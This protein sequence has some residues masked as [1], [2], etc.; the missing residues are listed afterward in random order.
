MYD[1]Y[2]L[3]WEVYRRWYSVPDR[4]ILA[5]KVFLMMVEDN[6]FERRVMESHGGSVNWCTNQHLLQSFQPANGSVDHVIIHTDGSCCQGRLSHGRVRTQ[7]L[8][9][10]YLEHSKLISGPLW[11]AACTCVQGTWCTRQLRVL[12]SVFVFMQLTQLQPFP[13]EVADMI[14]TRG[15]RQLH[16]ELCIA[17]VQITKGRR[18]L[19]WD[20][21]SFLLPM[22]PCSEGNGG[23]RDSAKVLSQS[24]GDPG[25]SKVQALWLNTY[26][27]QKANVHP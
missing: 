18:V 3:V 13:C 26:A 21:I 22:L 15:A 14:R 9:P 27:R 2:Q 20:M 7:R 16:A 11:C 19:A 6:R 25:L 12:I 4:Y 10:K 17:G 24:I 5:A 23:I 1:S 8:V